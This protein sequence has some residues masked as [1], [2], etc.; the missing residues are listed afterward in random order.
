MP[1]LFRLVFVLGLIAGAGYGV[2]FAVANAVKPQPRMIVE[3]VTL[4]QSAVEIRTGRS[5][6]DVL[7][8]QA[9]ALVRPKK[10]STR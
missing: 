6:A 8:H 9:S 7:D 4:P 1:T 3:A 2:L 5:V 10:H